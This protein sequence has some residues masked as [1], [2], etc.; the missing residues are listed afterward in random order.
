MSLTVSQGEG[1]TVITVISNPKSRWPVLCQI[2]GS[3][4]YGPV[5][6]A[7]Q[8]MEEKLT[9]TQRVIGIVQIVVAVM[10]LVLG[11]F[12]IIF[13]FVTT[14]ANSIVLSV[15]QL[16]VAISFCVLTIKSLCKKGGS[17]KL[18]E[19][20]TSE[21]RSGKSQ[22]S[23]PFGHSCSMT[24]A[25]NQDLEDKLTD[26]HT[27]LGTVQIMVGVM[28]ITV[29]FFG[30]VF[31]YWIGSVF[32]VVGI[33]CVLAVMFP[34][35][36]L[37]VITV[38]LNV[39]SAALAI[40][41]AVL[42]SIDLAMGSSLSCYREHYYYSSNNDW[43]AHKKSNFESCFYYK[44]LSQMML[45]GLD[46]MMIVLSVLQ[47]CVTISFCVLTGKALCK[48]DEDAKSVED[49]ELHKPLLEDDTAGAA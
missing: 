44:N 22:Y 41:A 39:V 40:T 7:S 2:L 34:H 14:S 10:N 32:L 38:A 9:D 25:L 15:F 46:I 11:C 6:F 12:G 24:L 28:N 30:F 18:V 42:Y 35:P 3:L 33:M 20:T 47:L 17:A 37:L 29:G 43:P 21:S 5:C 49:P 27:A 48:K 31:A 13:F 16:C 45:G 1:M 19:N 4:C 36:R 8:E 26:T 23:L